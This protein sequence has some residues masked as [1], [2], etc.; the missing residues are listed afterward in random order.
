MNELR[1]VIG[2]PGRVHAAAGQVDEALRYAKELKQLPMHSGRADARAQIYAMLGD[3]EQALDWLE[4][5]PRSSVQP[6][7]LRWPYMDTLRDHPRF[8]ALV[9][10]VNL[11]LDP[12]WTAPVPLPPE[13]ESL[14]E[15][16]AGV[17]SGVG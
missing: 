2:M 11:A 8:Q 9:H 10:D 14:P 1:G 5:E 12:G 3:T 6:A 16:G 7:T 4:W 15:D 17:G 13:Q